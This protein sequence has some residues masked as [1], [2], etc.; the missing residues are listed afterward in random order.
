MSTDADD[1]AEAA[2]TDADAEDEDA[3]TFDGSGVQATP[4]EAM[5][6]A[7]LHRSSALRMLC[8]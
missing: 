8:C 7:F 6:A 1:V 3:P 2:T 5:K 4:T